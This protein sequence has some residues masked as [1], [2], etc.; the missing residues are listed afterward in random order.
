VIE[1]GEEVVQVR[2]KNGATKRLIVSLS[3][4]RKSQAKS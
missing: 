3:K 1:D 2:F 4:I